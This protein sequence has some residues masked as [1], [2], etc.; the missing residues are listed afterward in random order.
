M[1]ERSNIAGFVG[2]AQSLPQG[3]PAFLRA[4]T[5]G[6]NFLRRGQAPVPRHVRLC[7]GLFSRFCVRALRWTAR[8]REISA[9]RFDA[10]PAL[11]RA[12]PDAGAQEL[13]RVDG[14]AVDPGFIVQMRAGGAAGG[15]DGADH[16]ADLDDVADPD[17]DFR[18]MAVAGRQ[19][20]AMVDLHHAAVAADPSG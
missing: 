3:R 6:K 12:E 9:D 1:T 14:F 15:A 8:E 4:D 2:L 18:E 13:L 5:G 10:D 11:S 17:M 16:L 20:V 7:M 19:S